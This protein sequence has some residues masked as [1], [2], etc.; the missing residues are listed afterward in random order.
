MPS[1]RG[2]SRS[3]R[4]RTSP[5]EQLHLAEF[6]PSGTD[7][8][9][10]VRQHRRTATRSSNRGTKECIGPLDG[11]SAS[12]AARTTHTGRRSERA[13]GRPTAPSELPGADR[14]IHRPHRLEL[15][16][17]SAAMM[18]SAMSERP[19]CPRRNSSTRGRNWCRTSASAKPYADAA[20]A[21]TGGRRSRA[22]TCK[23]HEAMNVE[24]ID[25]VVSRVA[26]RNP[27]L[28]SGQGANTAAPQRDS[29]F[30]P[31]EI[32]P[33]TPG[34]RRDRRPRAPHRPGG[35]ARVPRAAARRARHLARPALGASWHLLAIT[36]GGPRTEDVT[37]AAERLAASLHRS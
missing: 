10:L 1:V 4:H 9:R 29:R 26:S 7:P 12:I 30:E 13:E 2:P 15:G 23:G 33:P 32:P 14:R 6:Q 22:D 16:A 3:R 20:Q 24:L 21:G 11:C 8:A 36:A 5:N 17:N 25:Q 19:A 28:G 34:R 35:L 31:M 37:V 18:R 27:G